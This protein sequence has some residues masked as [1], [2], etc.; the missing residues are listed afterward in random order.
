MTNN[1]QN[2]Q[3]TVTPEIPK[4]LVTTLELDILDCYGYEYEDDGYGSYQFTN[5]DGG[6][7]TLK[8]SVKELS[9]SENETVVKLHK[10]VKTM[11][12]EPDNGNYHINLGNISDDLFSAEIVFQSL[13][14][15]PNAND[16]LGDEILLKSR[17][18]IARITATSIQ[19][20]SLS[21]SLFQWRNPSSLCAA[22]VV[23]GGLIQHVLVDPSHPLEVLVIDYDT[24]GQDERE[25]VQVKQSDGSFNKARVTDLPVEAPLIGLDRLYDLVNKGDNHEQ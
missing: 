3:I 24:Q 25:L 13:L 11:S 19:Q 16:L 7:A 17:D 6:A 10:L 15:K 22:I 14:K 1:G 12:I 5:E 8:V 4:S 18:W 9:N 21:H 2:E 20:A 23:K